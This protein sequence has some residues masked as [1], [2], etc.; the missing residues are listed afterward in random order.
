M[1]DPEST[2]PAPSPGAHRSPAEQPAADRAVVLVPI[3]SFRGAK[4]R[5]SPVL[6]DDERE[7]LSRWMAERVVSAAGAL[8][9]RIVTDDPA[10]ASWARGIGADL[11]QPGVDGLDAS[12]RLAVDEAARDGL[13]RVIVAHADLPAA[14][15]LTI[16]LGPGVAIV[17]DRRLDG[18]NVVGIPAGCGFEFAYGPGSF[19]RH[20]AEAGRLGLDLRIIHHDPLAWDV[21]EPGDLPSGWATPSASSDRWGR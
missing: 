16:A 21:D 13:D 3:R 1:P 9:C 17:P 14:D 18:S 2:R 8:R 4:S 6:G 15:D 10:V 12:V 5:L 11:A 19:R 7:Q 20:C